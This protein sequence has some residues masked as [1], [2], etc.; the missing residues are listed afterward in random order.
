M[1]DASPAPSCT[2]CESFR[3]PHVQCGMGTALV[4]VWSPERCCPYKSCGKSLHGDAPPQRR[5]PRPGGGVGGR[6]WPRPLP[7][8]GDPGP[9]RR[10][11]PRPLPKGGDPGPGGGGRGATA[12]HLAQVLLLQSHQTEAFKWTSSWLHPLPECW[13]VFCLPRIQGENKQLPC[14]KKELFHLKKS[15]LQPSDSNHDFVQIHLKSFWEAGGE[16]Q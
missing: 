15:L 12:G 1:S 6:A 9:E 3:C 13:T 5:R 2:V 16:W 11:R 8:G 7:K 14:C 10:A 4:E